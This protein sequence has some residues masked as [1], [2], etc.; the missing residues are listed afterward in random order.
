MAQRL[1]LTV[2]AAILAPAAVL[3]A[4][5]VAHAEPPADPVVPQAGTPCTMNMVDALTRLPDET[6]TLM[7]VDESAGS[8][9]WELYESP[10]PLSERWF[11]YGPELR[12][13]GQG[14]RNPEIMSGNWTGFPQDTDG[15]CGAEQTAVVAAGEVGPPQVV[16][17]EPGQPLD[18]RVVPSLFNI[19]FSG[20][21]L[22]QKR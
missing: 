10:Y 22:W 14:L 21:C 20:H 17:G 8:Y 9:Q 6:I 12:L 1:V 7:C 4:P 13:R 19:E 16:E 18:I 15:Q 3:V 5:V 2:G 11:S